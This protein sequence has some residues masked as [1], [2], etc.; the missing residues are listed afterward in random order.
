MLKEVTKI[1]NHGQLQEY[2]WILLFYSTSG[3]WYK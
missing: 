2:D 3:I 1:Q